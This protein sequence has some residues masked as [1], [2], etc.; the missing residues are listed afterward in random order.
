MAQFNSQSRIIYR[1]RLSSHQLRRGDSE[2]GH[3]SRLCFFSTASRQSALGV[4]VSEGEWRNGEK[5]EHR[6]FR[7]GAQRE[8]RGVAKRLR[9][10]DRENKQV[11]DGG[12]AS[13]SRENG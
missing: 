3:V 11:S 8:K 7:R 1:Q 10:E 6:V 13:E 4:K 5:N 2:W 9:G 12:R